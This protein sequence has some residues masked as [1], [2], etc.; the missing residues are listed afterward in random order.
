MGDTTDFGASWPTFSLIEMSEQSQGLCELPSGRAGM[1]RLMA[2]LFV[3][4]V[5]KSA[6]AQGAIQS[7]Q[8]GFRPNLAGE[9]FHLKTDQEVKQEKEREQAYKEGLSKIP[10]QKTKVDP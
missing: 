10:N 2:I 6:C 3:L 4:V 5:A 7:N 9:K 8:G 1:R